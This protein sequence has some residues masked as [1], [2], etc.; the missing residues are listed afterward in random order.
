MKFPTDTLIGQYLQLLVLTITPVLVA[1]YVA[2]QV[3]RVYTE[4]A[5]AGYLKLA[6]TKQSIYRSVVDLI[7]RNL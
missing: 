4:R 2:G 6:N 1:I 3:T 7:T 5:Y